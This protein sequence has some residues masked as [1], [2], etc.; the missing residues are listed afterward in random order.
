LPSDRY[1]SK[2]GASI[3]YVKEQMGHSSIQV[4]VDTYGH[5]IPGAN[6]CFVHRLA[7]VSPEKDERRKQHRNSRTQGEIEI[8]P[9][10]MQIVER[11]GGGGWT[12][13]ND[14]RIMRPS[15]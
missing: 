3:V 12:R 13:T 2:N 7:E 4:T 6:A 1:S 5:L 11:L 14:L 8:P 10:L 9:D 15:L